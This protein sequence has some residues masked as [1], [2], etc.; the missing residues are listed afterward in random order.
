MGG[1]Q[2]IRPG[3]V[4]EIQAADGLAYAQMTHYHADF[5]FLVSVLPSFHETRPKDLQAV[6]DQPEQFRSFYPLDA[7]VAA[8]MVHPVGSC[9]MPE[10]RRAFPVFRNG[11]ADR[12]GEVAVW[13]L[14]DGERQWR[15]ERSTDE[16]RHL[17]LEEI[18][19]HAL[20]VERLE[21]GWTSADFPGPPVASGKREVGPAGSRFFLYFPDERSAARAAD[22]LARAG[23][24]AG[25]P[26]RETGEEQWRIVAERRAHDGDIFAID[27]ELDALAT[28]LGGEYDG[29]EAPAG[30]R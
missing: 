22:E 15:A 8:K 28:R 26:V 12:A 5:G 20:L 23:Y 6:V 7:A 3:D 11:I 10:G 9:D 29:S 21:S 2:T 17:P 19:N 24:D 25:P 27:D 14:W 30:D 13:W 18:I 4:F 1:K 16:L